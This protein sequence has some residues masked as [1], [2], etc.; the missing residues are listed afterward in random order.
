MKIHKPCT[1]R[2]GKPMTVDQFGDRDDPRVLRVF[3]DAVMFEIGRL[4]GQTYVDTYA[5]KTADPAP[6]EVPLVA[7]RNR[8][9]PSVPTG[10]RIAPSPTIDL[11]QRG[12]EPAPAQTS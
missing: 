7:P 9:A 8:P 2:F 12:T 10:R 4:S 3:T 1:V 6:G 11:R 5:G